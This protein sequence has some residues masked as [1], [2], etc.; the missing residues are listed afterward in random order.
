VSG[1]EYRFGDEVKVSLRG[2]PQD[3]VEI[4]LR[5]LLRSFNVVSIVIKRRGHGGGP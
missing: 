1:G 4:T 5:V 3:Q 2:V